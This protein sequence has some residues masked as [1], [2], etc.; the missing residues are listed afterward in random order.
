MTRTSGHGLCLATALLLSLASG[1]KC[2][3]GS[4]TP[5]ASP[6]PSTST[7]QSSSSDDEVRPVYPPQVGAPSPLAQRLCQALQEIPARRRAECC[8][9]SP[10]LML[11][12]ECTRMLS[13]ALGSGAVK[14]QA[15]AV[16]AC[17]QAMEQAHQGCEWVGPQPP[18]TPEACRGLMQGTLML[19]ARCRSSL[20]CAEGLH[21][22]GVGPTDTGVCAPPGGAGEL[23]GFSVDALAT[24]TRQDTLEH[25]HPQCQGYCSKRQCAE[26]VASGGTCT[27]EAQCA[28]GL[29]CASGQCVQGEVAPLSQPCVDEGC[30]EG[31]RCV[32]LS[33]ATPKPSGAP[34]ERDA[35]CL[36]GCIRPDA[37]PRGTCGP[38]C[39][40]L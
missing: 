24:Y 36:G 10:T 32:Q 25:P 40:A 33:C 28:L 4:G 34:C 22:H 6:A 27:V 7:A 3:Q 16:E 29:H 38:R 35:E 31:A 30:Q 2:G 1:C 26:P 14:L 13:A 37:G 23:C 39:D 12:G 15:P 11:A 8:G 21:C 17:A 20:E 5:D 9:G 18:S 19:G